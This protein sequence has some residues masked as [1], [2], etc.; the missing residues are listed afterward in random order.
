[1]FRDAGTSTDIIIGTVTSTGTTT[2]DISFD[3][4]IAQIGVHDLDLVAILNGVESPLFTN[5]AVTVV[6]PCLSTYF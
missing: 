3:P 1:V 4:L 5:I 2:A 6:D